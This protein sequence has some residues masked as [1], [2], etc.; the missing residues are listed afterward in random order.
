MDRGQAAND[1]NRWV[2]EV[3]WEAAN[4]GYILTL[5]GPLTQ[6]FLFNLR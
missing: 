5:I 1:E 2:F 6:Y 4:K 3:A